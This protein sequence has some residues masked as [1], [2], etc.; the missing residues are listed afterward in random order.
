MRQ[1]HDWRATFAARL[2]RLTSHE[3]DGLDLVLAGLLN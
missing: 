3:R 1:E 2:A